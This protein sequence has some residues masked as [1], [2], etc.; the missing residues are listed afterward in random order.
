MRTLRGRSGRN[1]RVARTLA[2]TALAMSTAACGGTLRGLEHVF[3]ESATSSDA[4]KLVIAH[5]PAGKKVTGGGAFIG[6]QVPE[7][8][9]LRS[10][11][12]TG[13]G[14]W[15]AHAAE[16]APYAFD[17]RV[18]ATAICTTVDP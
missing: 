17:W 12:I 5:C 16:V 1:W 3:Q 8:A 11:P 2:V 7:L 15:L 9:L 6:P 18:G 4:I 13:G 14:G 10:E